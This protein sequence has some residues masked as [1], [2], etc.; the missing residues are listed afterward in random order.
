MSLRMVG[1]LSAACITAATSR[2][3][4]S[5]VNRR[6]PRQTGAIPLRTR[7]PVQLTPHDR[8]SGSGASVR[9]L[10]RALDT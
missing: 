9:S 5:L 2:A 1:S 10:L 4:P 3:T 7:A 8:S 6:R